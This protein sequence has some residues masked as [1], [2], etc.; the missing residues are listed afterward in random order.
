MFSPTARSDPSQLMIAKKAMRKNKDWLQTNVFEY[1]D[2]D[3][4]ETLF[5]SNKKIKE[6][7]HNPYPYLLIFDDVLCDEALSHKRS[8][9]S[10]IATTGRHFCI[11]S[12]VSC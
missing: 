6:S 4:L 12:I 1:I 9:I 7:G 10:K 5:E 2:E 8:Y 3:L 11:S